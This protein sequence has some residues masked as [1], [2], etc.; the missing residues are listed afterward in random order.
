MRPHRPTGPSA[1][2][3]RGHH[4]HQ[5]HLGNP[6]SRDSGSRDRGSEVRIRGSLPQI[7]A[8][9]EALAREAGIAGDPVAV[10]NY[11]QHAEHYIRLAKAR[12]APMAQ[13]RDNVELKDFGDQ[14]ELDLVSAG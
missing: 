13:I 3:N 1:R 8:R 5:Q 11:L 9:Y 12:G 7:I 2:Q 14:P 10:Q 4:E 6:R